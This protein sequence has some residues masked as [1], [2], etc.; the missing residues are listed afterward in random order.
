MLFLF[1][2]IYHAFKK[3]DALTI[4]F[5]V[6][7]VVYHA[8]K[9]IIDSFYLFQQ[10][11]SFNSKSCIFIKIQYDTMPN[12]FRI[13]FCTLLFHPF[14]RGEYICAGYFSCV[15]FIFFA[16]MNKKYFAINMLVFLLTSGFTPKCG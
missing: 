5:I 11:C 9:T 6:L 2:I 16:L 4:C 1:N 12:L 3:T 15:I 8:M 14:L 7:I 13:F 10:K